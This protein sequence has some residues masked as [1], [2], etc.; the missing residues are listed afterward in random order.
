MNSV[1]EAELKEAFRVFDRDGNG[2]ISGAEL[3]H[4]MSSIGENRTKEEVEEIIQEADVDGDGLIDYE[5]FV[6]L[7]NSR[8]AVIS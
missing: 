6:K 5:E 7:V 3:R 1:S 4:V 8:M 2:F